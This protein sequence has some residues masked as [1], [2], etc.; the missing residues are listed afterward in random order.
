[1]QYTTNLNL[2]KPE[3]TDL[4]DIGNE[5]DNMDTLDEAVNGKAPKD[6]A[7]PNT[8]YGVGSPSAYG[9]VK[10]D[11]ELSASSENAVQN[12]VIHAGKADRTNIAPVEDGDNASQAYAI[13]EQFY[14]NN[15]LYK[16]KTA[17]TLGT[18]WSSLT[19]DTDYEVADNVSSQIQDI[20]NNTATHETRITNLETRVTNLESE[21]TWLEVVGDLRNG[22]ASKYAVGDLFT[23]PWKDTVENIIYDNPWRVNHFETCEIEDGTSVAGMWLQNKY[24]HAFGVQFSQSRAILRCPSGL[25]AGTYYFTFESEWGSNITAGDIV[26]FTLTQDVPV[27]GRIGAITAI[28]DTTKANWRIKSYAADGKTIIET[29][30]PTFTASGTDLGVVKKSVRNGDLNSIQEISRG[31]NR[32]KTSAIRQYLNSDA[33]AGLW[34]I[35]QDGWDIAPTQLETKDG[36]LRGM[37]Q[38]LKEV[39]LPVKYITYVNTVNDGGTDD[40]D[41]TYDKVGLISKEQMYATPQKAGEGEAQDYWKELNGTSTK[42]KDYSSSNPSGTTYE[43]LKQYAVE[44]HSSAQSVRLRS[45]YRGNACGTWHVR[46]GGYVYDSLASS[47]TRFEPLVFIG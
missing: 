14:R 45:A 26:C 27:D 46:S 21:T 16:A 36:F 1:M 40:Y 44:N 18:A 2:K 25:S 20:A 17:I 4:Y 30:T 8:T 6:H 23:D 47:A 33:A 5:N 12:K 31:W 41:V 35:P 19:L 43:V 38:G 13:G 9:H 29:V 11:N 42:F 7:S 24:A 10:V 37:P 3:A 22:F 39:L 34:W 15:V 28:E 32:W